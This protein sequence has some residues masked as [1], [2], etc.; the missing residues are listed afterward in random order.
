MST[1]LKAVKRIAIACGNEPD[2][3]TNAF[4]KSCRKAGVE[5]IQLNLQ[6]LNVDL[7]NSFVEN[8]NVHDFDAVIV[9]DVVASGNE[10]LSFRFDWI[11]ELEKEG[12]PV[13]NSTEAI[14]N[15]AS[16]FHT[17]Y[18]L[19][20]KQIPVPSTH[21]VQ[22]LEKAIDIVSASKDIVIKPLHG[23]KGHGIYRIVGN[24]VISNNGEKLPMEAE[25]LLRQ[26]IEERGCLYIQEF[27]E[28][29]FRDIRAFIVGGE[30][31]AAIYRSS[32]KGWINNLSQGGKASRCIL[33]D[34][35]KEL[36]VKASE[37][38]GTTYAG[39]DLIEGEKTDMVLEINATPSG[40][41]IYRT[42][43]IYP[44]DRIIEHVVEKLL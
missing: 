17:T 37:A 34:E 15:A 4:L 42:W 44:T 10:G 7:D 8:K 31:I 33:N 41:G 27:V 6:N 36:C 29:P 21:I 2:W 23:F 22:D 25:K 5:G 9:R 20:K 39:I 16:K 12:I 24:A 26:L 18:L 38:V 43:G 40:A 1:E 11:K 19:R 13:I 32:A 35:Q 28:N 3:T 14:Q 30:I